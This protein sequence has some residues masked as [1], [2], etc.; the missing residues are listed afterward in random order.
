MSARE[1]HRKL[2]EEFCAWK[3]T[4]MSSKTISQLEAGSEFTE[5]FNAGGRAQVRHSLRIIRLRQNT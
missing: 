5:I 2:F 1:Q 4:A 3:Y